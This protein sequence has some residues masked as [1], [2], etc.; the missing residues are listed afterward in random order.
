LR[1]NPKIV[2]APPMAATLKKLLRDV[3]I[4]ETSESPQEWMNRL[5]LD[6]HHAFVKRASQL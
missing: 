1:S 3:C 2:A 5:F 4:R 6:F